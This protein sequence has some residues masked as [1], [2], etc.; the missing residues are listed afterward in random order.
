MGTDITYV[1]LRLIGW[2]RDGAVLNRRL[3][4]QVVS[5][6]WGGTELTHVE[7]EDQREPGGWGSVVSPAQEELGLILALPSSQFLRFSVKRGR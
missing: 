5:V 6:Y 1:V 2:S 7:S 4:L 3:S